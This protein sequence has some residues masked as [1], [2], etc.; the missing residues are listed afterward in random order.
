MTYGELEVGMD[1]MLGKRINEEDVLKFYYCESDNKYYVGKRC[2]NF[3]YAEVCVYPSGEVC[4]SYQLSRYLPWGQ[5]I[6][7]EKTEWKEL[8]YPSEPKE[9]S[10]EKW[11]EGFICYVS[12][13]VGGA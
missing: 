5:H 2:G 12:K 4:L 7:N 3:Y 11:L 10:F 8:K 9:I 13:Y 6:V 1:L